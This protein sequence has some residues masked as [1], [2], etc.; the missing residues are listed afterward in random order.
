MQRLLSF[1]DSP[2]TLEH[3]ASALDNSFLLTVHVVTR[4]LSTLVIPA[5]IEVVL[6]PYCFH[7]SLQRPI[8]TGLHICDMHDL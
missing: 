6:Y 7:P 2:H 3:V 5:S 8:R 1:T 4:S